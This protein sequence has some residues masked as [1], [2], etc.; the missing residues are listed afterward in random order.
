VANLESN[1][2]LGNV[3]LHEMGHVLGIGSLWDFLGLLQ[4]RTPASG[5][6]LDTYFTGTNGLA[7]FDAV[8]GATYSGGQKVPVENSGGPGTANS[9]WR[10]TVFKNELMTGYLNSGTNPMS[11]VTVRSLIDLGYTVNVGAADAYTLSAALRAN[12][13][14]LS[15]PAVDLGDDTYHGPVYS[16]DRRGNRKLL[17]RR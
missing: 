9:H 12:R 17:F 10:E 13:T 14:G 2:Q 3:I 5:A 7:A 11:Q 4:N 1:N 6:S 8:G 16:I 15:A